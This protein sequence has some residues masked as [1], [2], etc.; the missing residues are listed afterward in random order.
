MTIL[1]VKN[2]IANLGFTPQEVNIYLTLIQHGTLTILELSRHTKINRT[3]L[4]RRLENLKNQNLIELIID[5]KKTLVKAAEI[6]QLEF[7]LKDKQEKINNLN[8]AFPNIKNFL[9]SQIGLN[10]S[11]TKVLFYRGQAGIKTMI[12]HT[13]RAKNTVF[14]YTYRNMNEIVGKKF[15]TRWREEFISR[16]LILND[17]FSD[18]YLKS[19]DKYQSDHY[20]NN[21]FE[22]RYLPD[23]ILT[24][25]C[26]TDIYND[27]LAYYNW[28]EGEVFGVE[29]YNQKIAKLQ[30]QIFEIIWQI[31]QNSPKL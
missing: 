13:L 4:Y 15:T 1:E 19:I 9:T 11:E 17:I 28:H 3:T 27:V 31:A 2:F 12:W 25:D 18:Q 10:Q 29:I 21:R 22:S 30:K 20:L 24:I 16:K 5:D 14:G 7:L 8:N 26:Q 6:D 23:K